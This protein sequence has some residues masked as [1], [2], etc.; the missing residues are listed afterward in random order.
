M[1]D[2]I[3]RLYD[4]ISETDPAFG[5]ALSQEDFF[6]KLQDDDYATRMYNWI[7]ETDTEFPKQL[8]LD[9]FL[10]KVKKKD[11]SGQE[12]SITTNIEGAGL[13][14]ENQEIE[15]LAPPG[16]SVEVDSESEIDVNIPEQDGEEVVTDE[17]SFSIEG[18]EADKDTF[19]EYADLV[20]REKQ[21]DNDPFS[22][23]INEIDL[24][25][26]EGYLVPQLNYAFGDYGFTFDESTPLFDRV[27]VTSSDI[28]PSTGKPYTLDIQVDTPNPQKLKEL[29]DFLTKHKKENKKLNQIEEQV[30]VKRTKFLNQ[31]QIDN[32]IKRLNIE[33]NQLNKRILQYTDDRARLYQMN[34]LIKTFTKEEANSPEGIRIRQNRNQL[35][36]QLKAEKTNIIVNDA[37]LAKRGEEIDRLAGEYLSMKADQ[38]DLLGMVQRGFLKGTGRMSATYNDLLT[39]WMISD[40][41]MLDLI[42]DEV[43]YGGDLAS[44][45]TLFM[46][47]ALDMGYIKN[48]KTG[49]TIR[50]QEELKAKE[51]ILFDGFEEFYYSL[52]KDQRE[53]VDDYIKDIYRKEKKYGNIDINYKTGE[54]TQKRVDPSARYSE[55]AMKQELGELFEDGM[56]VM[57]RDGLDVLYGDKSVTDAFID[58]TKAG[59]WGGALYGVSESLPAM[60]EAIG[61]GASKVKGASRLFRLSR[62]AQGTAGF[63]KLQADY[64]NE[65]VMRN[66]EM[67]NITEEERKMFIYPTAIVGSMLERF[68]FRNI[69]NQKGLINK[70]VLKGLQKYKGP[71]ST[72]GLT[73]QQI[74]R[75][76]IESDIAKGVLIL[77]AAGAA[78]FETGAA[79]ELSTI[80]AK[81]LYNAIKDNEAFNTP[82]S[83]KE[84]LGQVLYSG[85]Q[86][87]AGGL[88]MGSIP[89]S[90]TMLSGKD[91][92]ALPDPIF[93]AFE[94]ISQDPT[95]Y[96]LHLQDIKN[97]INN[98]NLT[99]EEAQERL[100]LLNDI[101]GIIPKVPTDLSV[102]KR[103]EAVA[104]LLNKQKLERKRENTAPELRGK[105]DKEISKVDKLLNKLIEGAETITGTEAGIE[106]EEQVTDEQVE[107]YLNDINE[108]REAFGLPKLELTPELLEQTK[109]KLQKIQDDARK[110][111]S[112]VPETGKDKSSTTEEVAEG[113]SNELQE[114]TRE[115]DQQTQEEG[116][117][118]KEKAK[119]SEE[120]GDIQEFEGETQTETDVVTPTE[121]ETKVEEEVELTTENV[122]KD[123]KVQQ[124]KADVE[125]DTKVFEPVVRFAKRA[126]RAISKI[127]PNVN[128]I[129]HESAENFKKATGKSGRGFYDPT[130]QNIHIDLTKG[131]RK[132]VAHEVF[133]AL[134]LNSVKTNAQARAL[135]KRMVAAVAKAKG[136]TKE[137]KQKIE[138]FISNYDAD[139][140]NEEKLAEILGVLADGY[141]KLDA[142]TK[143]RIRQWIE[144]IAA[145]LGLD[146]TQFTKSDQDVIDLLN[147]VAGKLAEGKVITKKDVKALKPPTQKQQVK[148]VLGEIQVAT[149]KEITKITGLPEPTVRRILGQ[150]AK[151]GELTRVAAGVY[152][153]KTKDGKTTAI[154]QGADALVEIK[155]LVKEGAK[156]DMIFLDPPYTAPGIKGGNRNLAK[157]KK[158]T[159]EQFNEFVSDV[160]KLLR[161]K[162][163]PVIFMFSASKSNKRMLQ[164]YSQAFENNGLKPSG[165][166]IQTG[167]LDKQGKPK[168]MFGIPL[169]E[170]VFTFSQ[171]GKQ[172]TD[173]DFNFEQEYYFP[174]DSKYQT[175]KPVALLEA[176]IKAS[177]KAGELILDPFAGSGSTAK[178]AVRKGRSVVTIEENVEQ[179]EKIKQEVKAEQQK[180]KQ[181]GDQLD[182]FEGRE[183]KDLPQRSRKL[184]ESYMMNIRG[185][186]S[187][188]ALYDP[189][190][191]RRELEEMGM[192][193][194]TARNEF[195]GE[196]TG[197]YFQRVSRNGK[198]Y[199][200]NPFRRQ[201]KDIDSAAGNL[202]D[203]VA[204]VVRLRDN[205]FSPEAIKEYLISKKNFDRRLVNA[206]MGVSNFVLTRVPESFSKI[207]GGILQGI[208]LFS[209]INKYRE[210]LINNN[211]TPYGIK[212]TK[213]TQELEA[214]KSK[215]GKNK[216]A[217]E[218]LEK[219]IEDLKKKNPGAKINKLT[220]TQITDKVIEYMKNQKEY[221]DAGTTK[222]LSTLQA[223][224]EMQIAK[225]F[226]A[227]PSV[228]MQN[229]I[230]LARG[231]VEKTSK[232]TKDINRIKSAI[233]NYI[234]AVLPPTEYSKKDII[235]LIKEVQNA[236]PQNIQEV[237]QKVLD[238]AATKIVKGLESKIDSLLK[239]N[240]AKVEGGRRKANVVD[241]KAIQMLENIRAQ[242]KGLEGMTPASIQKFIDGLEVKLNKLQNETTQDE[243]NFAQQTAL[244]V[245]INYAN[246]RLLDDTNFEKSTILN[247]VLKDLNDIVTEGRSALE[248]QKRRAYHRYLKDFEIAWESI[249]GNKVEML[250]ENPN[251]DPQLPISKSNEQFIANPNAKELIKEFSELTD[252]K[253]NASKGMVKRI[254]DKFRFGILNYFVTKRSDLPLLVEYMTRIPGEMFEGEFAN[255]TSDNINE[256]S[257]KYKFF[258]LNDKISLMDILRKA[259][260]KKFKTGVK[261]DSLIRDTGIAINLKKYEDAKKAYDKDPSA[262]NKAKLDIT[263]LRLSP[264]EMAYLVY[265]YKD[266]AN[267]PGFE[268]KYGSEYERV[269]YEMEQSLEENHPQVIVI[270]EWLRNE[271]YPMLYQRYNDVYKAIYRVDMPWNQYYIGPIRRMGQQPQDIDLL[272]DGG[273]SFQTTASPAS[274]K[275]RIQ[276]KKAIETQNLI[277]NY[278][279]YAEKMNWFAA[280]AE[281]LNRVNKLFTNPDIANILRIKYPEGVYESLMSIIQKVSNKGLKNVDGLDA[282]FNKAT[283]WFVVGRLGVNPTIYL[284]QLVSFPTYIN[285]IGMGNWSKYAALSVGQINKT[286]KE[287]MDNS[288]YLQDR[289]SRSFI[290]S[291]EN[292]KNRRE[293]DFTFKNKSIFQ[294]PFN[295]LLDM[296][297]WLVKQGDKGAIM[298][299]GLP[300]YQ[301]HKAQFKKKNPGAT[302][303]Q[304]IDYAIKKFEKATR[305]TQQSTDLQN[306]DYYQDGG[307]VA[308]TFNMFK[309]SIIQYL[310]KE[311][312]YLTNAYRIMKSGFK[313]PGRGGGTAIGNFGNSLRGFLVYHTVLPVL[314]QYLSAGLPG[315]LAPWDEEDGDD[316]TRAAV[317]GNFNAFFVLGD[318]I[319]SFADS[320]MGKPWGTDITSLPLIEQ[321]NAVKDK[322]TKY[323]KLGD[324]EEDIEK[325]QTILFEL[326]VEDIP[327]IVG[328]N[329]KSMLRWYKNIQTL[330]TESEDPR[331]KLLRLFNFSNYQIQ[332][333]EDRKP[334]NTQRGGLTQRELK[335]FFPEI[336]EQQRKLKETQALP[337]NLQRQIDQLEAEKK[338]LREEM[339]EKASR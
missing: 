205:N 222:G 32:S 334:Q 107:Q 315:I 272:A 288:I 237:K 65:E 91:Y 292:Y 224:M 280:Y 297:M 14:E 6:E 85:L 198:P 50:N 39:D 133:H 249:T 89:A 108:G 239:T 283:S 275:V 120:V 123:G 286:A 52:P 1:N 274:S 218:S 323:Y 105:I 282:I 140:Q 72:K 122:T 236:T 27:K 243:N 67:A 30:A 302:E 192:R 119:V 87:A 151:N 181:K 257:N 36:K 29:Q 294:S 254:L 301:F 160:V 213:L 130:N 200:Y 73:F 185:F 329:S 190:R 206:V 266:P 137:Q 138:D 211:L 289:Y 191:L 19:D 63:F 244:E 228:N 278:M 40:Y 203:I 21:D 313:D 324:S 246:S 319:T 290:K 20:K 53:D 327:Q 298:I 149:I 4:W 180:K 74:V 168:Q 82:E 10:E 330:V 7:A 16:E 125:V 267:R 42:S 245:V 139:I 251:F 156:F 92:S 204:T 100:D 3:N 195:T 188:R 194:G 174:Q 80:S 300:V 287:I 260:G 84:L 240:F 248:Q 187:A 118:T 148:D 22:V 159:P 71:G 37:V 41:G 102:E 83:F 88:Y 23:A 127:L 232:E 166:A 165:V 116:A 57:V 337:P 164:K 176:I 305:T 308:R 261:Q 208:K 162:N 62:W 207:E 338:R 78:E 215:K 134:L 86:E 93:A 131:D 59:F 339:L 321:F 24:D 76:E 320:I 276:N 132:T 336:Y 144:K 13:S 325:G 158:L 60:I 9:F 70:Y 161:N 55:T 183:Q 270:A 163:T 145:R 179:A 281:T 75:N 247:S 279:A 259:Y 303:Q 157:Y 184:A 253:K 291:I 256:S 153:L 285:E 226:Y 56:N 189:S 79:Q 28:N 210:K 111:Q 49:E 26:N 296:Q 38:G 263:T 2:Y 178:A 46:R 209:K 155:K 117:T 141:T 17:E 235:E 307:V 295:T 113:V 8:S 121:T 126:G 154:V 312:I 177:T 110:K 197:Y 223:Q 18:V 182:I 11:I 96:K 271:V 169:K 231:L 31:E 58:E 201:Q 61:G 258:T 193:L 216:A 217:I 322:I 68:G 304:A 44:Y 284:K 241:A 69:I 238:L 335:K 221:I 47:R 152:T 94:T 33:A 170:W 268:T 219:K 230:R 64:L 311:I 150:G 199:F 171:S 135:T 143:S 51:D 214:V 5:E 81:T 255:I 128:I 196:I 332:S 98:G 66:P 202:N 146:V 264:M 129:L 234:R 54:V 77:G 109:V 48:P 25:Y 172:R 326:L 175:S 277:E 103:K 314:F 104:L 114:S 124:T 328:I 167:K 101:R 142:P 318:M 265:Q 106:Q 136:L 186:I 90:V 12:P 173:M 262:E 227:T 233:R 310:R 35:E 317:I 95:I 331:K 147:T 115:G 229:Q 242:L 250:I 252:A 273:G 15:S 112:P 99:K 225:S 97:E 45:Q 212:I 316:L 333:A 299:G 306:R 34:E 309:T 43:K 293:K 269:M 220:Q